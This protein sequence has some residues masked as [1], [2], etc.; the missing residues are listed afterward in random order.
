LINVG[1][2]IEARII[3]EKKKVI[4]AL[5]ILKIKNKGTKL[6]VIFLSLF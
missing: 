1:E 4:I 3:V 5:L 6:G 2:I